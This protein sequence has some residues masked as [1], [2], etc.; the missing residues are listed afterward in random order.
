[1]FDP[2]PGDLAD[3]LRR[4]AYGADLRFASEIGSTNDAALAL[5]QAGAA[6]GTAVLAEVQTAGRGRRGRT[7]FS[8]PGSGIYLSVVVR[9]DSTVTLSLVTLAAGVAAADAVAAASGL[10]L[11]LKWPNDLVVGAGWRKIGGI[12]CESTSA[13]SSPIVVVGIGINRGI[14]AF[15]PEL[16]D[17]ATSIEG[18]LGRPIERGPLVAEVLVQLERRMQQLRDRDDVAVIDAWRAFA[19]GG[20]GGVVRWH[21][22]GG[23]RTGLARDVDRDGAL[24]VDAGG[25]FERIVAGEVLWD[26][27]T[28]G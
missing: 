14:G 19:K 13:A 5:A 21:D 2:L 23:E 11:E 6:H 28:H 26:R 17:R 7:W 27:R 1:M 24:I 16:S 9:L 22:Q 10:P 12:L 18:E 15:P 8:P 25:Q 4:A 3:A 20:L